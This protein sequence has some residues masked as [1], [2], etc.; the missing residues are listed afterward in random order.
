MA[1]NLSQ[2]INALIFPVKDKIL[3]SQDNNIYS[4]TY[5][6]VVSQHQAAVPF[7]SL[8]QVSEILN[9]MNQPEVYSVLHSCQYLV[10]LF[11]T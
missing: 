3:I 9:L 7:I 1:V 10:S 5:N 2:G 8:Y 11:V 6:K 4:S